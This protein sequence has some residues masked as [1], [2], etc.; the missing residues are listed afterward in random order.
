M[1]LST[2]DW[3]EREAEKEVNRLR[4]IPY[5]TGEVAVSLKIFFIN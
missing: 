5:R 2:A 3:L 4:D 1:A